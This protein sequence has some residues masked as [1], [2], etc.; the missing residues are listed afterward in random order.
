MNRAPKRQQ[1]R[2]MS[3]TYSAH[4]LKLF[5]R[6]II[7]PRWKG[8]PCATIILGAQLQD[9]HNLHYKQLQLCWAP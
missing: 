6:E 7:S 9:M 8:E 1:R 3:C 4:C 2:C 5:E